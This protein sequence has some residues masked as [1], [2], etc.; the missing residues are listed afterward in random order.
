M[1]SQR[2]NFCTLV[3]ILCVAMV[4]IVDGAKRS[5]QPLTE[6]TC[7]RN[8]NIDFSQIHE[9][10]PIAYFQTDPVTRRTEYVEAVVCPEH[11][12]TGTGTNNAAR[13]NKRAKGGDSSHDAGHLIANILGGNVDTRN[14]IPQPSSIN[15]GK[16]RKIEKKVADAVRSGDCVWFRINLNYA[17]N[18]NRPPVSLTYCAERVPPNY[19]GSWTPIANG[20]ISNT[21]E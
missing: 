3:V 20:V 14:I 18:Q 15:R 2:L 21:P 13:E 4:T 9:S 17:N 10:S 5:R 1:L 12:N 16:W 19:Q 11:L 7:L 6:T 8:R